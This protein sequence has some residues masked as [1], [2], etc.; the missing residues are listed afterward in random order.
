MKCKIYKDT[1][2]INESEA[3][4]NDNCYCC[5]ECLIHL[6]IKHDEMLEQETGKY[7]K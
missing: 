7:L 2:C 1:L 6:A 4:N 3:K 5:S